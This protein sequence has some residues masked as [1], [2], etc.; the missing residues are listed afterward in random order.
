[1]INNNVLSL[2]F[3]KYTDKKMV[4]LAKTVSFINDIGIERLCWQK[5][6]FYSENN[7]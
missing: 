4:R 2:S 7:L 3:F 6:L 5:L 1:M